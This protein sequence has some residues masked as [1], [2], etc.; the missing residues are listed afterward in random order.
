MSRIYLFPIY[1]RPP[2]TLYNDFIKY[3]W[4]DPINDPRNIYKVYIQDDY[5]VTGRD[6]KIINFVKTE[7]CYKTACCYKIYIRLNEELIPFLCVFEHDDVV[8]IELKPAY[9]KSY[10]GDE[11]T[12]LLTNLELAYQNYKKFTQKS[13]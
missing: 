11:K 4:T 9:Q 1:I 3:F 12:K 13:V 2:S 10:T 6:H 5:I 8:D 7:N